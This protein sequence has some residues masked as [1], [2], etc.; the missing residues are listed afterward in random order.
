MDQGRRES[1][2][3]RNSTGSSDQDIVGPTGVKE[4]GEIPRILAQVH[5]RDISFINLEFSDVVGI[6]KSVT[7]PANQFEDV[8]VHGKWFDGSAIESFARVAETDMYLRPDLA[9]FAEIPWRSI[10]GDDA[11]SRLARVVCD[12]LMPSG[13]RFQGD[14]RAILEATLE[15]AAALDFAYEVAPELEFFLLHAGEGVAGVPL[16]TTEAATST[17]PLI[18]PPMYAAKS[19]WNLPPW[20][21][22]SKLAT[23]RSPLDSMRWT[24]SPAGLSRR[25]M[26][27]PLLAMLS[28]PLHRGMGYWPRSFLNHSLASTVQ[29]CT[30][31]SACS[32]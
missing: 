10:S 30:L 27:W 31:T 13:E 5:E 20:A 2:E 28:G 1:I 19:Y 7:I 23:M 9:T 16:P 12:V 14:P 26:P 4:P 6:A 15:Y 18:W 21:S 3:S 24:L 17:C 8:L 29:A 25:P 11:Q 32:A 22:P